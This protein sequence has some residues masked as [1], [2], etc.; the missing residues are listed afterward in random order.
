MPSTVIRIF[1][2]N[3]KSLHTTAERSSIITQDF[4]YG[5]GLRRRR[6][7][8]PNTRPDPEGVTE[9]ENLRIEAPLTEPTVGCPIDFQL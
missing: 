3:P 2:K 5:P 6:K 4:R 1:E 8:R 9:F 7:N